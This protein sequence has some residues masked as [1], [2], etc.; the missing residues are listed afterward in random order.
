MTSPLRHRWPRGAPPRSN[1]GLRRL[2]LSRNRLGD[3][4]VAALVGPLLACADG[5]AAAPCECGLEELI[6][7]DN[8]VGEDGCKVM[9][10]GG[11]WGVEGGREE[12]R[13]EMGGREMG[14]GGRRNK[15]EEI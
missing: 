1:R 14:E 13:E 10:R 5:A 6:L 12:R 11:G 4:G 2:N 9:G 3:A 15:G 7:S 8:G